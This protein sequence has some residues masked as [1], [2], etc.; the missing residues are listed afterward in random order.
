MHLLSTCYIRSTWIWVALAIAYIHYILYCSLWWEVPTDFSLTNTFQN[1]NLRTV[2]ISFLFT[3][4]TVLYLLQEIKELQDQVKDLMFYLETQQKVAQTS[5]EIRQ[6]P[7][8]ICCILSP[9]LVFLNQDTCSLMKALS[10]RLTHAC[11]RWSNQRVMFNKYFALSILSLKYYK[12][13]I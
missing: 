13:C 8:T 3:L 6:V 2:I 12:L 4:R 11:A 1:T 10:Y 9:Q 5:E 7:Y